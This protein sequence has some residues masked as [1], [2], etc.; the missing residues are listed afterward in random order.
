MKAFTRDLRKH[1]KGLDDIYVWHALC[2][3]WGGVRPGTT[4]LNSKIIPCELSRGLGGTMD[5]LAVVKI[6]E[7]GIG[8][9]HPDQTDDFYDSMHSYLSKVGI[10]GVKVDVIHTLE[11][12]SEEYGGR[13]E[14]AKK[15]YNGYQNP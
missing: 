12:V 4:H 2:G 7:G 6:V 13:V 3:A 11:Y 14:L 10:T 5:D 1:F 8:L 9:V 15:Y